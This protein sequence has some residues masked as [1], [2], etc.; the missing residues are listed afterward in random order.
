[1]KTALLFP[2]QGSQY[3]GMGKSLWETFPDVRKLYQ[4]ANDLLGFDVERVCFEG[5]KERLNTTL[6]TQPILFVVSV[7]VFQI[8]LKEV[9]LPASFVAGHSLGEYPALVATGALD[10]EEGLMLVQ[11]RATFMQESIPEGTG[12]MA[13]VIGL[14]AEEVESI[15]KEAADGQVL[16]LANYNAPTQIVLSG[17]DEPLA[18]AIALAGERRAKTVRL[19]VSAPFHSPLMGQASERLA[20]ALKDVE[21]KDP[22]IPWVSNVTASSV[23]TAGECRRLL[24]S[25]VCSPV[26]W[27]ASI[28]WMQSAGVT[29]FIELGPQKVLKGLCRRIDPKIL[30]DAAETHD[31][32]RALRGSV[33]QPGGE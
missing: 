22:K 11:K 5:P 16:V 2:G 25:Q 18:R 21:F 28:R 8:F 33:D 32:L 13:A 20:E 9:A 12:G 14:S 24:S 6:Y 15:C 10:F 27:E 3:V 7:A 19:P 31:E 30:C 4:A 17:E 23:D 26:R 1:M 29:R